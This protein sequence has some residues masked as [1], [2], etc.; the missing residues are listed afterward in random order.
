MTDKEIIEKLNELEDLKGAV[1]SLLV[2][3]KDTKAAMKDFV[4]WFIEFQKESGEV[5]QGISKS[6]EDLFERI[7]NMAVNF[8]IAL[9]FEKT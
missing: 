9:K 2:T 8:H 3:N 5:T 4:E 7:K 1:A 6:M